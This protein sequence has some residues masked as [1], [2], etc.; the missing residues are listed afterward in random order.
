MSIH[1]ARATPCD[2]DCAEKCRS[3]ADMASP[4]GLSELDLA[5]MI[6]LLYVNTTSTT[7][8]LFG[9]GGNRINA[10]NGAGSLRIESTKT[11]TYRLSG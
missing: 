6:A 9:H 5:I 10:L 7:E 8:R 1:G 3:A 2:H 4:W 11:E